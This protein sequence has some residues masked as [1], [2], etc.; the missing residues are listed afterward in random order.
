MI[1]W[2]KRRVIKNEVRD[3][4]RSK[5]TQQEEKKKRRPAKATRE[6][7]SIDVRV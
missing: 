1:K 2:S 6:E 3:E 4:E 7:N 5:T